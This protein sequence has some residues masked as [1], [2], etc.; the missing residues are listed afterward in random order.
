MGKGEWEGEGTMDINHQEERAAAAPA[1]D[2]WGVSA[3][4]SP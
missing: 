1:G 3:V 2:G 4:M